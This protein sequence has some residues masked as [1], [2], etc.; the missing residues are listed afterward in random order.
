M[1]RLS[2]RIRSRSRW[3]RRLAAAALLTA[4]MSIGATSATVAEPPPDVVP[5]E[6]PIV[7][8]F[9][10]S[11]AQGPAGFQVTLKGFCGFPAHDILPVFTTQD[12]PVGLFYLHVRLKPSPFGLFSVVETVPFP[13]PPG[14]YRFRIAC[15]ANDGSS[16][17]LPDAVFEITPDVQRG[18]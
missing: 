13:N 18:G 1:Y 8:Q 2:R 17:L 7:G 15:I 4:A 9:Q 16:V 3:A 6:P 11:P 5:N 10:V 12:N 14:L